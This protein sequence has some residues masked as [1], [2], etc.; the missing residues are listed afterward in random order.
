MMYCQQCDSIVE[1]LT[2]T[3]TC[4]CGNAIID[5]TA[6]V[7][8]ANQRLIARVREWVEKQKQRA[9]DRQTELRKQ[10]D[11]DLFLKNR[12]AEQFAMGLIA[13]LDLLTAEDES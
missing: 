11:L 10:D 7:E 4:T 9:I 6:I 5:L 1:E 12:G 13:Y 8:A 2:A 3:G